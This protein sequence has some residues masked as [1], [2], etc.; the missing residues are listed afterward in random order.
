M[1]ERIEI[2]NVDFEKIDDEICLFLSQNNQNYIPMVCNN[3]PF[4]EQILE[5]DIEVDLPEWDISQKRKYLML[6]HKMVPPWMFK[7]T[8][9]HNMMDTVDRDLY[10]WSEESKSIPYTVECIK[11]FPLQEIGRVVLYGSYPHNKVPIHADYTEMRE[12]YSINFNPGGYRPLYIYQGRQKFY[13][14]EDY[15]FYTYD[16]NEY[17]GVD[18]LPH[19]SYT[20]RVDGI[21]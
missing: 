2:D 21:K 12:V 18:A 3:R 15:D 6:K 1:F 10:D 17:H 19:F 13:L 7:V 9:K 20:I 5:Y 11:R 14:P 16:V 4:Q 8:F